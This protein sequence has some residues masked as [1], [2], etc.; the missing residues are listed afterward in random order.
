LQAGVPYPDDPH[1]LNVKKL[2]SNFATNEF[3]TYEKSY[4]KKIE[5]TELSVYGVN[6]H[7]TE[8]IFNKAV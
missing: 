4:Q 7:I 2:L 5:K 6:K 8:V 3:S 1:P